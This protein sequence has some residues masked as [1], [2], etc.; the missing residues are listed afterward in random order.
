MKVPG[1]ELDEEVHKIMK[2]IVPEI[3][4]KY[5][6]IPYFS[7]NEDHVVTIME[8]IRLLTK[9]SVLLETS[10]H[11]KEWLLTLGWHHRGQWM[12][13]FQVSAETAPHVVC[14]GLLESLKY[15]V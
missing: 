7:R 2:S 10:L 8:I 6:F 15:K 1:K 12:K 4:K 14:L 5:D 3:E 9:K 13:E 11:P